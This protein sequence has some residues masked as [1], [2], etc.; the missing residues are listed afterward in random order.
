MF[1]FTSN[2]RETVV[3]SLNHDTHPVEAELASMIYYVDGDDN[4]RDTEG[5]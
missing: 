2:T 1:A 5:C 3:R 4:D